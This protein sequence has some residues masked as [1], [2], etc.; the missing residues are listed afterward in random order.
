MDRIGCEEVRRGENVGRMGKVLGMGL[1]L[2]HTFP[3]L[4]TFIHLHRAHPPSPHPTPHAH[5]II[6]PATRPH[7]TISSS[8][9]YHHHIPITIFPFSQFPSLTHDVWANL[10]SAHIGKSDELK[11]S[12]DSFLRG[13]FINVNFTGI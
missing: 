4:N 9:P 10:Y 12:S 8:P 5:S 13:C 2:A 7:P 11:A 3:I 6:S 1:S